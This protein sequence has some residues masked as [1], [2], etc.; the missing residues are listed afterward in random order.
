MTRWILVMVV[1]VV[2]AWTEP[3]LS[4]YQSRGGGDWHPDCPY[5]AWC[6]DLVE[7]MEAGIGKPGTLG[8]VEIQVGRIAPYFNEPV[9]WRISPWYES[10][11]TDSQL[12]PGGLRVRKQD[13]GNDPMTQLLLGRGNLPDCILT[14]L[15]GQVSSMHDRHGQPK[16][17]RAL[18]LRIIDYWSPNPGY[19]RSD[20]PP[21]W[22][23]SYGLKIEH[24]NGDYGTVKD[25]IRNVWVCR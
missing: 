3:L 25:H 24:I 21:C 20:N 6:I 22:E 5:W 12:V 11:V 7:P 23:V 10:P 2:V 19:A 14:I 18:K 13:C 8:F 4:Q 9:Q 15:P 1:M 16:K 17:K